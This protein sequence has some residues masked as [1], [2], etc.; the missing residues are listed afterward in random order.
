[1]VCKEVG[2]P[3]YLILD[4]AGD[5]TSRKVKKCFR[6]VGTALRVLEES[7]QWDN[8]EELYVGV[9]KE[10]IIKDIQ[11]TNYRMIV[12]DYCAERRKNIHNVTPRTLFQL[13]GNTPT[14]TTHGAQGDISNL[15]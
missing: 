5:K 1:M 11:S 13:N 2:V 9:F 4:P 14:V 3:L 15:C 10:S 6:Q 8:Q 7:T 12:S